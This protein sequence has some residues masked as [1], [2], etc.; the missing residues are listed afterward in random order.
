VEAGS[1]ARE[2]RDS[3]RGRRGRDSRR[4]R[5]SGGWDSQ[6]GA[7]YTAPLIVS[8][9]VKRY[10]PLRLPLAVA[11]DQERKNHSTYLGCL[12]LTILDPSV[13]NI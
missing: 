11:V 5:R 2:A 7:V 3:P 4:G 13:F 1:A 9:E 12:V 6:A 10:D 8:R